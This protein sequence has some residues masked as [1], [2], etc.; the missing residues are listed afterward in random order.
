MPFF[1]TRSV[2][3]LFCLLGSTAAVLAADPPWKEIQA[4]AQ[5]NDFARLEAWVKE[6]GVQ[7]TIAANILIAAS[8]SGDRALVDRL[9]GLGISPNCT[10]L[11]GG[12][13]LL[14]TTRNGQTEMVQHLLKRGAKANTL[15][16]C[17]EADCKGH[18]PLLWAA[19]RKDLRMMK[20]LLEAGADARAADN[21]AIKKANENGDVES[22]LLL[23]QFGGQE[24]RPE[25]A[26]RSKESEFATAFAALG[27]TELLPAKT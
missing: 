9:L 22:F 17:G 8:G 6:Q 11:Y 7:S 5:A 16:F 15:A 13:P 1:S 19:Y 26:A 10:N 20:M 3:V 25:S 23:K 12:T 4:A 27:L 14:G 2:L 24:Q 21:G 18:T